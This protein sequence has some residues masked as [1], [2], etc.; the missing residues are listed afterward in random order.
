MHTFLIVLAVAAVGI[1]GFGFYIG[2]MVGVKWLGE[3]F[4]VMKLRKK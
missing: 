4:E 1:L 2:V 3:I